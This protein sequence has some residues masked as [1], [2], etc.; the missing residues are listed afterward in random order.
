MERFITLL[1]R[2]FQNLT[3]LER[4]VQGMR[5]LS[6]LLIIALSLTITSG[7]KKIPNR[8]Y[9]SRFDTFSADITMG[10]FEV[11][12]YAVEQSGSASDVNNGVGLTTSELYILTSYTANQVKNMPQYITVSLFGRCDTFFSADLMVGESQMTQV[13]NSTTVRKCDYIGPG[14]LFDYRE[15]LSSLGLNIV[16]DYAYQ[17]DTTSS[18]GKTS[19]YSKYINKLQWRKII[20]LRLLYAVIAFEFTIAV[21]TA[22]YYNIKGRY[23]N[24]TKERVLIHSISLFSLA[25]LV[26][27]LTSVITLAWINIS[28]QSRI[29]KELKAFG[30]SYHLGGAW[31]TCVWMLTFFIGLSCFVWSGIEWCLADTDTFALERPDN[32]ILGYQP[33][34][35]ANID[36]KKQSILRSAEEDME[37]IAPTLSV[38]RL[39]PFDDGLALTNSVE[40]FE[41]QDVSLRSSEESDR[42]LQRVV[43]PSPTMQF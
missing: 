17:G 40:A 31:F 15:A 38:D 35:I 10:L 33:G 25:V 4:F 22:W 29:N 14:Y 5:I 13:Q 39:D 16:L 19:S 41:L 8:L 34:V 20:M 9:M 6:T 11:L 7:S 12:K 21:L 36:D 30:F 26:C 2:P 18:D 28:L 23:I 32:Q 3:T 27:G 42:S 1:K 37:N 43:K 24:A